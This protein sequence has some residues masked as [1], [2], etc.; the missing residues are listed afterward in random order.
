[1]TTQ[2]TLLTSYA[3]LGNYISK[4]CHILPINLSLWARIG[5]YIQF[6]NIFYT[7]ISG[8]YNLRKLFCNQTYSHTFHETPLV[9]TLQQ[10]NKVSGIM[11]IS[12]LIFIYCIIFIRKACPRFLSDVIFFLYPLLWFHQKF[13]ILF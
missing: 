10:L 3:N 1:M 12:Y 2:P 8:Y 11:K 7:S 5:Y 4:A 6:T 13:V 9:T